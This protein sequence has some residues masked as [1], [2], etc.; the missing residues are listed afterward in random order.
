MKLGKFREL[1]K[2][3]SDHTDMLIND[4]DGDLQE[5]EQYQ[6][7]KIYEE[8]T[9]N[10]GKATVIILGDHHWFNGEECNDTD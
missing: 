10:T 4:N 2:D 3:L 1:T 8:V 6:L 7:M 9:T 5:L